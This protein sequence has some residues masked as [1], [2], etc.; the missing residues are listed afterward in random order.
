[1]IYGIGIDIAKVSRFE[2]WLENPKM[3]ERFF[4]DAEKVERGTLS[5]R[6]QHYASRFA[7]KE[8]F[9]KALGTG[10]VGFALTEIFVT[11]GKF[12]EP[13]INVMGKAKDLLESRCGKDAKT[14]VSISHEKEYAVATVIIECFEGE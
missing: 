8:A 4:N 11:N 14:F 5:F 6:C 10:I 1:M 12:G 7:A 9:S 13:Y 2:K 3:I